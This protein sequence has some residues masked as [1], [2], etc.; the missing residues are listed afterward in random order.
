M[1]VY[2]KDYRLVIDD[3]G[4]PFANYIIKWNVPESDIP[5]AFRFMNMNTERYLLS[6]NY[7][8]IIDCEN[9]AGIAYTGYADFITAVG[10]FFV[11]ALTAAEGAIDVRL[12]NLENN[13]T[14]YQIFEYTGKN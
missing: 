6:D 7:I 2:I 3:L 12:T 13:E 9:E 5:T 14:I 1:K 10:S 11:R 4:V 8:N